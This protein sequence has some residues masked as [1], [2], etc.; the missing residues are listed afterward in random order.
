MGC[1]L[2]SNLAEQLK[3]LIFFFLFKT[4][5]LD[6]RATPSLHL[7]QRGNGL[8]VECELESKWE[9]LRCSILRYAYSRLHQMLLGTLGDSVFMGWEY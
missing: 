4:G 6:K 1:L 8:V 3:K 7:D 9:I 5:V 2:E